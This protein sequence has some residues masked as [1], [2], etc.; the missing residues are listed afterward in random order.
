MISLDLS[1]VYT[2]PE[3]AQYLGVNYRTLKR[4][5]ERGFIIPDKHSAGAGGR[6]SGYLFTRETLDRYRAQERPKP[7]RRW[8]ATKTEA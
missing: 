4:H 2:T 6:T 7:G 3:A 8:R 1:Q 5:I